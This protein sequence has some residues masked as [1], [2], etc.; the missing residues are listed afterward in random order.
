MADDD[1]FT[2]SN[3]TD[4]LGFSVHIGTD[5][6]T[7]PNQQDWSI[8]NP[9]LGSADI[10]WVGTSNAPLPN[11]ASWDYALDGKVIGSVDEGGW[12]LPQAPTDYDEQLHASVTALIVVGSIDFPAGEDETSFLG[13]V[14]GPSRGATFPN[15]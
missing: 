13:F 4:S 3:I 15:E 9:N 11:P 1:A 6:G 10:S 7:G 5:A 2:K 12:I 8:T 14:L